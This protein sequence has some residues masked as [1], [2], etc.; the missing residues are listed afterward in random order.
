MS[1]VDYDPTLPEPGL[2]TMSGG[3]SQSVRCWMCATM[4]ADDEY[5]YAV[6]K[7]NCVIAPISCVRN[8]E[9]IPLLRRISSSLNRWAMNP[10]A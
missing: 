5:H 4:I 2:R 3:G 7:P 1:G 6:H 8:V 10:K 9:P